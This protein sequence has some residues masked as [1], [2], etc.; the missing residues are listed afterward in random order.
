VSFADVSGR[1]GCGRGCARQHRIGRICNCGLATIAV[2]FARFRVRRRDSVVVGGIR[3]RLENSPRALAQ[4]TM[5]VVL[6]DAQFIT[7]V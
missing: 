6:F 4:F 5:S 3:I 1:A 7:D 2:I